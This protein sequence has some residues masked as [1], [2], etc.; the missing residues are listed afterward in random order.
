MAPISAGGVAFNTEISGSGPI[1][2]FVH[3]LEGD[4]RNW[5]PIV[6]EIGGRVSCFR[7]DLRGCGLS[8]DPGG[9][10][11]HAEDL[12]ALLDAAGIDRCALVGVSKGAA[13]ALKLALDHPERVERLVLISP[14]IVAWEWS[15]EW[16]LIRQPIIDAARSGD[17][18]VARLLWWQHPLFDSTRGSPAGPA[19][20]DSIM[21]SS[22]AEWFDDRQKHH[23]PDVDR[24]PLLS[25]PTLLLSGERD[26]PDFKLIADLMAGSSDRVQRVD[27]A[28]AG[29][30]LTLERSQLCA[31]EILAFLA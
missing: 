24:I 17:L 4:L 19:L 30:M 26:L 7:Y 6:D 11:D 16:V 22:C 10:F 21:R 23:L 5:D 14:A 28:D 31:R 27:V 13:T 3:G 12:A 25:V 8:A 29:H 1:A 20:H 15:D 18:A 9:M 2:V